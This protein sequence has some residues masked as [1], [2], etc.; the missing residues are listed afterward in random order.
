[1]ASSSDLCDDRIF[2]VSW[3]TMV[4]GASSPLEFLWPLTYFTDYKRDTPIKQTHHHF[5]MHMVVVRLSSGICDVIL[6]R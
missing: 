5:F 2:P 3:D 6:Y 1:M 4:H